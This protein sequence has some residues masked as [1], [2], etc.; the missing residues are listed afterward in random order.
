MDFNIA[1]KLIYIQDFLFHGDTFSWPVCACVKAVETEDN[2]LPPT[3]AW[4]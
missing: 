4:V 1:I 2:H 3:N